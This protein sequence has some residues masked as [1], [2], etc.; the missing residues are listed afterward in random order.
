LLGALSKKGGIPK[1]R[2][3]M[4]NLAACVGE[5]AKFTAKCPLSLPLPTAAVL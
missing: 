5:C 1:R 2:K 3:D 4:H